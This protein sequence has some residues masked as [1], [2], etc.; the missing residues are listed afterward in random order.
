VSRRQSSP[1][2]YLE[3][4]RPAHRK[5]TGW[6]LQDSMGEKMETNR[7]LRMLV[8]PFVLLVSL[9]WGAFLDPAK[10]LTA[11]PDSTSKLLGLLAGGSILV[12]ALGFL[13]SSISIVLL[14][15]IVLP[16]RIWAYCK[17]GTTLHYEAILSP[18][19]LTRLSR[20][21]KCSIS[22]VPDQKYVNRALYLAAAFDHILLPTGI[23]E[24]LGRRWNLFNVSVHC[25]VALG[26]SIVIGV[27]LGIKTGPGWYWAVLAVG[28]ALGINAVSAWRETAQM[29]DFLSNRARWL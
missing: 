26:L 20:S 7:E 18:E 5:E 21:L 14:R 29:V 2:A 19:A 1:E 13:I 8:P 25:I 17:H 16:R 4:F 24:W 28:L 10:P 9:C 15:T 11:V 23:H 12:V 3:W 6:R 27:A 22:L